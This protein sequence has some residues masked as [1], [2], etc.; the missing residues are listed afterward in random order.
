[1]C[2]SR[3]AAEELRSVPLL[4]LS[5]ASRGEDL[6]FFLFGPR[7]LSWMLTSLSICAYL[8]GPSLP[9]VPLHE[10]SSSDCRLEG[11]RANKVKHRG[12]VVAQEDGR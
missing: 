2:S 7:T 4:S 3:S 8:P 10:V 9:I 11:G 5:P 12:G 6:C 1:M